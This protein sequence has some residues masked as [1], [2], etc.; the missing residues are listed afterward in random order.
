MS[1]GL[2]DVVRYWARRRPTATAL[3]S[4]LRE[5]SWAEL[6][7]LTDELASGFYASGIGSGDVVAVLMTNRVEFV[8]T[9][10]ATFKIGAIVEL[11]NIRLTAKELVHP[12]LDAGAKAVVTEPSVIELLS[13]TVRENP[14][15]VIIATDDC[16]NAEPLRS[17]RRVGDQVPPVLVSSSDIAVISYTSGTTGIPKG[18]QLSHGSIRVGGLA[19]AVA[20]PLTSEDRVLL[21]NPMAFSAGAITS[22]LSF[23][24]IPGATAVMP[25]SLDSA[26]L[27]SSLQEDRITA[28]PA[29]TVI[30]DMVSKDPGFAESD[31]S[32]LRFV[33]VG[34][35]P[36]SMALLERWSSH[37][38]AIEQGYGS[39]ETAAQSASILFA[40]DP[41]EKMGSAGRAM[42]NIEMRVVDNEDRE[43]EADESGELIIRGPVLFSGYVNSHEEYAKA[44]RG[45][46]F[47]TGDM[48]KID[49]EGFITIVDRMKDMFQSGGINV[50]P[51]EVERV[52]ARVPGVSQLAVIGVPDPRW[53]EVPMV[54]VPN[55]GQIDLTDLRSIAK[56]ELADYKRP[57]YIV[58]HGKSLPV[59]LS[60]K[61][62]KRELRETYPFVPSHAVDLKSDV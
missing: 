47:H 59:T 48:A 28:W 22:Y 32:A 6:D 57:R 11:L 23:A 61:V 33:Q 42:M 31:L 12:I 39:T 56:L 1:E 7:R 52:L 29:V 5:I 50:Y 60:G 3:R 36:V 40:D 62:L 21:S 18:A 19:H 35:M 8:E 14:E 53:G 10:L 25:P 27:L 4:V 46:W 17:F 30:A 44:M 2:G 49:A 51:A 55:F 37:G 13:E 15:L 16:V 24:M 38:V 43:L 45:G 34:G 58:E 9:M 54:V 26:T 20:Q 41:I